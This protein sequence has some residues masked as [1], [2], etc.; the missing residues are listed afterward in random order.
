MPELSGGGGGSCG[1][2]T[3]LIDALDQSEAEIVGGE[4]GGGAAGVSVLGGDEDAELGAAVVDELEE[5]FEL[6]VGEDAF[7]LGKVFRSG[8]LEAGFGPRV[9]FLAAAA[10]SMKA[11]CWGRIC[12]LIWSKLR[13]VRSGK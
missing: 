6:A 2:V 7:E 3:N 11:R 12:G 10:A 8:N 9:T 1:L 13:T 4:G 5:G